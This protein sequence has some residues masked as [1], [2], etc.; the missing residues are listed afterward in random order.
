MGFRSQVQAPHAHPA[1]VI[2]A[3]PC[4][5]SARAPREYVAMEQATRFRLE[6]SDISTSAP[7]SSWDPAPVGAHH[8]ESAESLAPRD[9]S[10]SD[11]SPCEGDVV[12]R[13]RDAGH[14]FRFKG[15]NYSISSAC[16]TSNH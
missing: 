15:V 6:T 4:A 7:G 11:R 12:D 5:S 14:L 2:A 13:V 8:R 10:A 9:P 3:A 16:A 1:E